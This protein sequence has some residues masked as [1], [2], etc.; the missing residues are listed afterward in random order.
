MNTRFAEMIA[1]LKASGYTDQHVHD[2]WGRNWRDKRWFG[3][4]GTSET[5]LQIIT[6]NVYIRV[7]DVGKDVPFLCL[8]YEPVEHPALPKTAFYR[9]KSPTVTRKSPD[10]ILR[11][12]SGLI[13]LET[14][15][16]A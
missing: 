11:L 1:T 9:D 8:Q 2:H 7:V 5:I 12:F 4:E 3:F 6:A 10:D 15:E 13:Q 16:A 14:K